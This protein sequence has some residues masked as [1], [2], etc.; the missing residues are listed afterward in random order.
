MERHL[1]RETECLKL[2][3]KSAG[4]L[5]ASS[6]YGSKMKVP[7]VFRFNFRNLKCQFAHIR[8]V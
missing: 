4:G 1:S 6:Y 8:M 2:D 7:I 5:F 3:E